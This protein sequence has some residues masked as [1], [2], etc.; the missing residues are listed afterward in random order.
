MG[1]DIID[2]R[3]LEV[4]QLEMPSFT[5]NGVLDTT[6]LVEFKGTVTRLD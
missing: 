3:P 2:D 4:R 5:H 1:T 6:E